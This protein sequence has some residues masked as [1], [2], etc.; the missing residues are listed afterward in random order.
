MDCF[1][2]I[3]INARNQI[4]FLRLNW[5]RLK[6]NSNWELR[7]RVKIDEQRQ[8]YP[9]YKYIVVCLPMSFQMSIEWEMWLWQPKENR[10]QDKQWPV[11]L[12]NKICLS[13]NKSTIINWF[14]YNKLARK[15]NQRISFN[16]CRHVFNRCM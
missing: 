1:T 7:F 14:L 2:K 9:T 5:N 15:P 8:K 13:L 3:E 4:N 10:K 11:A 12:R 16:F 6:W